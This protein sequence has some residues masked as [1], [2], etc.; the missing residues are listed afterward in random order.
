MVL[1]VDQELAGAA[2][3]QGGV[4]I[5]LEFVTDLWQ[6]HLPHLREELYGEGMFVYNANTG[7]YG[8]QEEDEDGSEASGGEL[9]AALLREVARGED[10]GGERRGV[11]DSGSFK[12]QPPSEEESFAVIS[13]DMI[14]HTY[15]LA[16]SS[17]D[18]G[19]GLDDFTTGQ[20][21]EDDREKSEEPQNS[22][23]PKDCESHV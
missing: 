3:G 15:D 13:E 1:K 12:L 7:C 23:L 4:D 2:E 5:W 8:F 18:E 21:D 17:S 14:G 10:K 22:A 6:K 9:M 16:Q 19:E 11:D 20:E